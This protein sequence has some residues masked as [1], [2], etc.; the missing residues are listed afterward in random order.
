MRLAAIIAVARRRAAALGHDA[1][2]WHRVACAAREAIRRAARKKRRM[3]LRT[4]VAVPEEIV[5]DDSVTTDADTID[6]ETL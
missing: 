4:T 1:P 6:D 3:E 5:P 2:L